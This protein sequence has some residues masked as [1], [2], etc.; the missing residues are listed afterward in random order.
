MKKILFVLV[1]YN[2]EKHIDNCIR[3]ILNLNTQLDVSIALVDNSSNDRSWEVAKKYTE[4]VA[5][6][7]MESNVGF[8]RANNYAA[9]MAE[10]DYYFIFNIDAYFGHDFDLDKMVNVLESDEKVVIS[11]TRLKYPD[12]TPQTSFF[13]YS[14]PIKWLIQSIPY[15]NVFRK[16]FSENLILRSIVVAFSKN[17]RSYMANK[18]L[19]SVDYDFFEVEWVS[20]ASILVRGSYVKKYGLF[21]EG[22]FLYGEDED[23]CIGAHKRCF[24]VVQQNT[25]PVTHV[26]G[27]NTTS[28][29]NPVVARYKEDSLKFFIDKNFKDKP[30]SKMVMKILLPIYVRG[31]NHLWSR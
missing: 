31:W 23:L 29:F 19:A 7:Q 20:G 18:K 14:G 27:W 17:A 4:K 21:D 16:T 8:G 5:L 9:Y 28:K 1:S 24:K 30:I 25:H 11:S 2:S 22:I 12:G 15:Y 13:K 26:H 10:A 6:F 3:S